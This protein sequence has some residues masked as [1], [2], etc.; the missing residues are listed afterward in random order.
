MRLITAG[1]SSDSVFEN[2]PLGAQLSRSNSRQAVVSPATST[3]KSKAL[4]LAR[5]P[6]LICSEVA[7]EL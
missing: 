7:D 4:T 6:D 3:R 2:Y 1:S 5:R